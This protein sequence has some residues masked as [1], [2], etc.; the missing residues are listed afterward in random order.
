V[1]SGQRR[2]TVIDIL[3]KWDIAATTALLHQRW[4]NN[5]CAKDTTIAL[6]NR[7]NHRWH[8]KCRAKDTTIALQNR[9]NHRWHNNC[10]ANDTMRMNSL[11]LL[12]QRYWRNYNCR[13][14][15]TTRMDTLHLLCQRYW[16]N[17]N[18]RAKDT[19]IAYLRA[20]STIEITHNT[21]TVVLKIQQVTQQMTTSISHSKHIHSALKHS[22]PNQKLRRHYRYIQPDEVLPIV[23]LHKSK[24]FNDSGNINNQVGVASGAS[25]NQLAIPPPSTS[26][27]QHCIYARRCLCLCCEEAQEVN[28]SITPGSEKLALCLG[29]L[30]ALWTRSVRNNW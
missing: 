25:V 26:K 17:Y 12:C 10:R 22:D 5:C 16:Q 30:K 4:H 2:A 13:A 23:L 27:P 18:C 1:S 6:Q 9:W 19:T 14:K 11:H 15:D 29:D 20:Q 24:Q 21:I 28:Y 3:S 7:W 8:Y